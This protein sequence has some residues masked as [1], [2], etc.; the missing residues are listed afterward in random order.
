MVLCLFVGREVAQALPPE[1]SSAWVET[2]V[3]RVV[4]LRDQQSV[5][6]LR[7]RTERKLLPIWVGENEANVIR[8]RL[9]G[10]RAPRPS[11]TICWNASSPSSAGNW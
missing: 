2:E 3:L 10:A 9:A 4:T 5:V 8:M 11:P 6:V 1:G 7:A